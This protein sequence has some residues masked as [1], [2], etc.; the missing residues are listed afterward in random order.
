V[1][2]NGDVEIVQGDDYSSSDSRALDWTNEGG[3][4]PDLTGST[5]VW[6]VR[7]GKLAVT[8][9]VIT[10]SG[11]NQKVRVEPTAAQT[12]SVRPGRYFFDTKATLSSGRVVTLVKGFVLV[13]DN[14][15][16]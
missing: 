14:Q 9:S 8:G 2:E 10:P 1:T 15:K 6:H 7:D 5:I 13:K 16:S 11:I 12:A 3:T 4:W